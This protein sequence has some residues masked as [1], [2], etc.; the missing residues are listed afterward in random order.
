[1]LR[2]YTKCE[3]QDLSPLRS[4][5]MR[6]FVKPRNSFSW[7]IAMQSISLDSST[8]RN[9][10]RR[11]ATSIDRYYDRLR[12]VADHWVT[13]TGPSIQLRWLLSF[14]RVFLRLPGWRTLCDGWSIIGILPEMEFYS[15]IIPHF[16]DRSQFTD[17]DVL[18]CSLNEWN[19]ILFEFFGLMW[20]NHELRLFSII[21]NIGLVGGLDLFRNY[22]HF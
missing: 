18:E 7:N 13:G 2:E 4:Q 6:F 20:F 9:S 19:F 15:R 14:S 21:E 16:W 1:M 8:L 12:A 22:P 3:S 17:S 11:S 10:A 5:K